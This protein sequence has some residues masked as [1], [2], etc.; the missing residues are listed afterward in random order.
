MPARATHDVAGP[1]AGRLGLALLALVPNDALRIRGGRPPRRVAPACLDIGGI[2]RRKLP[3]KEETFERS[4]RAFSP[5]WLLPV[6]RVFRVF[7][8]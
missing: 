6:F 4:L 7:R 2:R 3:M 1:L 8:G 5:F